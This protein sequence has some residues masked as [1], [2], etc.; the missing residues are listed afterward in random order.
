MV[1]IIRRFVGGSE[2]VS[3]LMLIISCVALAANLFCLYLISKERTGE[4]HMRA[5]WIFSK[6]DVLANLGVIIAGAL[7][8]FTGSRWPDLIIGSIITIVV[9]RGGF[10]ILKEAKADKEAQKAG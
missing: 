2:P 10:Q 7:I 5:S 3:S 1:D 8:Y 9:L 4:V 6:N